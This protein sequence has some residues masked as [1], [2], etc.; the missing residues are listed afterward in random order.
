MAAMPAHVTSCRPERNYW[1]VLEGWWETDRRDELTPIAQLTFA[2]LLHMA[3]RRWFPAVMDV[4]KK[5]LEGLVG[6]SRESVRRALAQ[7]SKAGLIHLA[8]TEGR[9]R[10]QVRMCYEAFEVTKPSRRAVPAQSERSTPSF[11]QNVQNEDAEEPPE[12]QSPCEIPADSPSTQ[13]QDSRLTPDC[14]PVGQLDVPEVGEEVREGS[15]C[16][17]CRTNPLTVRFKTD[18]GSRTKQRFLACS[19][20]GSGECRGF[21]WNLGSTAYEPSRRVLSL[22]LVGARHVPGRPPLARDLVASERVE[23]ASERVESGRP[24][25]LSEWFAMARYLPE[26]LM[27]ESLSKVDS[28]LAERHRKL[29]SGK[30]AILR[31]VKA[32]LRGDG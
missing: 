21:T 1:S 12:P 7:L 13:V 8:A 16:P 5:E 11:A 30:P 27:L 10:V 14:R 25:D 26:D 18:P 31:E 24:V 28:E 22:A 29:G 9:G 23:E 4:S 17:R 32:R 2:V 3:N 20:Y 6:H 19:G 15:A